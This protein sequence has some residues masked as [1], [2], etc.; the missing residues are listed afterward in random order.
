M[1]VEYLVVSSGT[2][3]LTQD[4]LNL[5]GQSDWDLVQVVQPDDSLRVTYIFKK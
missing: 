5:L 1:V 3:L 2:Q 4:H